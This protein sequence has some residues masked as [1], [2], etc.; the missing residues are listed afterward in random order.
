MSL[1]EGNFRIGIWGIG[2]GT[3]VKC[4][5]L[6][7]GG[8][9][10]FAEVAAVFDI[11]FIFLG[12]VGS[13]HLVVLLIYYSYSSFSTVS[14]VKVMIKVIAIPTR[15]PTTNCVVIILYPL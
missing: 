9:S 7:K 5:R 6:V 1:K 11:S 4:S 8:V 14:A 2:G 10:C 13:G 15:N 3:F 12:C